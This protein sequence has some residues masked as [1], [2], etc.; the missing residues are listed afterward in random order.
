MSA[1]WTTTSAHIDDDIWNIVDDICGYG[2][3]YPGMSWTISADMGNHVRD[4]VDDI[5]GYGRRCLGHR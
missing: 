3:R 1:T 4:I 5:H 2:R